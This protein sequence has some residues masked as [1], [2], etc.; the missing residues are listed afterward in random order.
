MYIRSALHLQNVKSL[1]DFYTSRNL[2]ALSAIYKQILQLKDKRIKAALMFAFTNTAWHGSKM[3]RYN[4]AGGHRPLSGTLYFPTL[5]SEGNVF[6]VFRTKIETLLKYYS[7]LRTYLPKGSNQASEIQNASATDLAHLPDNS[8]DYVFTDPPFGSNIFYADCNF[9]GEAWLGSTTKTNSEA[10][11]NK[12]LK[13]NR[14]G[15]SVED[16]GDLMTESFSEIHRVLKP[17]GKLDLVFSSTS[18]Q[19]WFSIISALEKAGFEVSKTQSL[20]KG[21]KSVKGYK[22]QNGIEDV[23]TTDVVLSLKRLSRPKTSKTKKKVSQKT[24]HAALKRFQSNNQ[25]NELRFKESDFFNYFVQYCVLNGFSFEEM[26]YSKVKSFFFEEAVTS[27][28]F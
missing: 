13:T 26:D 28:G 11:V 2:F 1:R 10:V 23:V 5:H 6:E 3:R 24:I 27:R 14:G 9:I 18:G 12:S 20:E 25:N 22:S 8:I 16:Y 17:N 19:V 7:E 4:K 21:Q 15:K